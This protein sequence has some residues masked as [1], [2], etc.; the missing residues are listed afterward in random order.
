MEIFV[1]K[2]SSK[3]KVKEGKK[4]DKRKEKEREHQVS[5]NVKEKIRKEKKNKV[6]DTTYITYATDM[7]IQIPTRLDDKIIYT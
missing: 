3:H 2:T 7:R 5:H 4:K 6:I 1:I